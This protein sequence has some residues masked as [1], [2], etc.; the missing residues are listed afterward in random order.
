MNHSVSVIDVIAKSFHANFQ[1]A[2]EYY[3]HQHRSDRRRV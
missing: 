2:L 3:Q 1:E